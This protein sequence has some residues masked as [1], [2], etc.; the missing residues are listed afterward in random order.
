MTLDPHTITGRVYSVLLAPISAHVVVQVDDMFFETFI[1]RSE[2]E[3]LRVGCEVVASSS[4]RGTTVRVVWR[5]SDCTSTMRVGQ[6]H[7]GKYQ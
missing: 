5:G 6:V 2:A 4:E 1:P 7:R 3:T